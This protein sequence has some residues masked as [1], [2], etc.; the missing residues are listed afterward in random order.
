MLSFIIII[1]LLS[2]LL[3]PSYGYYRRP[4]LGGLGWLPIIGLFMGG[5][6]HR[7]PMGPG[8]RGMGHGPEGFGGPRGGHNGFGGPGG[9]R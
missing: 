6:S 8:A 1:W 5:M 7:P 3:R 4:F 2:R 9:W